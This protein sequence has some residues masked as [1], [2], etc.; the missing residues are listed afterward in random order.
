VE[1]TDQLQRLHVETSA[2]ESDSDGDNSEDPADGGARHGGA[3]ANEDGSGEDNSE[4]PIGTAR[5]KRATQKGHGR[6]GGGG[7]SGGGRGGSRGAGSD[8]REGTRTTQVRNKNG[9]FT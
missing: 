6:G 2:S 1:G 8:R 7:S 3:T 4:V 9:R 5:K